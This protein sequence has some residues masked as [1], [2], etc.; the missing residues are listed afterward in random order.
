MVTLTV[1]VDAAKAVWFDEASRD[2]RFYDDN[3]ATNG[4][5]HSTGSFAFDRC[6]PLAHSAM[7]KR[8]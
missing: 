1:E 8:V 2:A 6:Y 4:N 7:G 5:L 3:L